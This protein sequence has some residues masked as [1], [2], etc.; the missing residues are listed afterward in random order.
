MMKL[1]HLEDSLLT[2]EAGNLV[3][4][5]ITWVTAPIMTQHRIR[6][7]FQRC[8]NRRR[9]K[10]IVGTAA[11]LASCNGP[12]ACWPEDADRLMAKQWHRST[13]AWG[14]LCALFVTQ[15]VG[16]P[17]QTARSLTLLHWVCQPISA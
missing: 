6:F 17:T 4:E 11:P 7:V 15:V 16:V 10:A 2:H 1:T 12:G 5:L 8:C 14:L 13:T 9:L 3:D